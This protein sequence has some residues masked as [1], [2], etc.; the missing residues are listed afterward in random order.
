MIEF[1]AHSL[2]RKPG[3]FAF[4]AKKQVSI[5]SALIESH[6]P[7]HWMWHGQDPARAATPL[8]SSSSASPSS[9]KP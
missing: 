4:L 2:D 9:K 6:S 7:R 1:R 8:S 3:R 5:G